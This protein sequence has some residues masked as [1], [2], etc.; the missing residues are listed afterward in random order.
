MIVTLTFLMNVFYAART[1][2]W[3]KQGPLRGSLATT[4]PTNIL[5][6]LKIIGSS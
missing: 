3:M 4:N 2:T 1:D 5:K 6:E